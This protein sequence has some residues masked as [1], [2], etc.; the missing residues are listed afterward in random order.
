LYWDEAAMA[1]DAKFISQTGYDQHGLDWLQVI[2]PSWGDYKLP[3]Y[4]MLSGLL[5]RIW[6]FSPELLARLPSVLAGSF[7]LLIIYGLTSEFF[8]NQKTALVAAGLAAVS[9]INLHLSR[10]GFESNLALFFNGLFLLSLLKSRKKAVWLGLTAF[11][12][13]ASFFTY[14]S[15]R[16]FLVAI[17]VLYLI[18]IKD[19]WKKKLGISVLLLTLIISCL[20]IYRLNPYAKSAD[21]LR[22]STKSVM[23]NTQPVLQSSL[24]IDQTGN[25]FLN[26]LLFH[27]WLFA[28]HDFLKNLAVHL[29]PK[30]WLI[31]YDANPRHNP[32]KT[33]ALYFAWF[34]FLLGGSYFLYQKN[35]K[36]FFF[37]C[38]GILASIIP[39]AATYEVPHALRSLNMTIFTSLLLAYGFQQWPT[40]FKSRVILFFLLIVFLAQFG[41]YLH[42]YL[43]HYP[44]RAYS[45][46][47]YGYKQAVLM[48]DRDYVQAERIFFSNYYSRAYLYYLLYGYSDLT[49]FQKQNNKTVGETEK[50]DK[51]LFRQPSNEEINQLVKT[52]ILL[53]YEE[54]DKV[55][56]YSQ[57]II[58]SP[59][60]NPI[61]IYAKNF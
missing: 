36:T 1:L 5:A 37:I 57:E 11:S 25:N 39:A 32:G 55:E 18:L 6:S 23:N 22:L 24:I 31:S 49:E 7:F 8:H 20:Y 41:A 21:W 47:Q 3:V 56:N 10:V 14:Y 28:S 12:G 9:P 34:P 43:I 27:R 59:D 16:Y 26:R 51:I 19:N 33:G 48:V 54:K 30:Y 17:V 2:Y 61:F 35:K 4:I 45:D 40:R 46:F 53:P 15:S 50:I 44:K 42:D 52:S 38:L 58:N 29:G 60:G 13:I